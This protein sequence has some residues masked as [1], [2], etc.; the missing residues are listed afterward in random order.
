MGAATRECR[1]TD[2]RASNPRNEVHRTAV[3]PNI[4]HHRDASVTTTT[5]VTSTTTGITVVM[6]MPGGGNSSATRR[7]P[8]CM[9]QRREGTA[10]VETQQAGWYGVED[11]SQHGDI[12][13]LSRRPISHHCSKGRG[14]RRRRR[15]TPAET[16]TLRGERY[17]SAGRF[18]CDRYNIWRPWR[19]AI[20]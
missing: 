17:F 20:D 11:D 5:T 9:A 6:T 2:T 16:G 10:D 7:R 1:N 14:S 8:A 4:V 18:R 3:E 13:L 15:G 19:D 12:S